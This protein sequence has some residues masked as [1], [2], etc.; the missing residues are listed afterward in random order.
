MLRIYG[1]PRRPAL[2][3]DRCRR[4]NLVC[5]PASLWSPLRPLN[6]FLKL[7]LSFK[8]QLDSDGS[9]RYRQ[10]IGASSFHALQI[11]SLTLSQTEFA[12]DNEMQARD[13]PAPP[14]IPSRMISRQAILQNLDSDRLDILEIGDSHCHHIT[15]HYHSRSPTRRT[16]YPFGI[17]SCPDSVRVAPTTI[18]FI[19]A[20]DVVL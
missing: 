10:R 13:T 20:N 6:L 3:L 14:S 17:D 7:A 18:R 4:R 16:W 19:G 1:V 15:S 12:D 5:K 11:L 8:A 9:K 2:R